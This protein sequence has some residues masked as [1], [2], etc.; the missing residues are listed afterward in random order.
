MRSLVSII[1]PSFN[2]VTTINRTIQSV[3]AQDYPYIE[4]IVIDGASSD[5]TT[6]IL[7]KN[8]HLRWI[9]EPDRGQSDA[10]NKGF[11][12]AKGEVIGW[13]N[14]DDTYN[15]GAV[16]AAVRHLMAEPEV[17]VVYSH[18]NIIDEH[19]RVT[20][21]IVAPPFDLAHDL[22]A[23]M[24]PQP[25]AFFRASA[26]A[27][28]GYVNP[29]LHYVMDRDLFMR[30]GLHYRFKHV[31]ATWANFRECQGTK[32]VSHPERFWLEVVSVFEQFLA[33]SD[34]PTSVFA[35]KAQ[36]L[37]R[38]YWLAGI[39][40]QTQSSP[41]AIEQGH[42][43]CLKALE[44]Y[45]LLEQDLDFAVD[46]LIHWAITQVGYELG[47]DYVRR[48][49]TG[50]SLNPK[51]GTHILR[52]ALGHFYVSMALMGEQ[53]WPAYV[54]AQPQIQLRWLRRGI[55]YDPRWLY[56]RGVLATMVRAYAQRIRGTT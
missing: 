32:T 16:S 6:E 46:Q 10:L 54:A 55:A 37:A 20:G 5:G 22:L 51:E 19:D 8:P 26:L 13:L 1:T 56:N 25:T 29:D 52:L 42:S 18:C 39:S 44:T 47:E 31:D 15:P 14:A 38:A 50:L 28:V 7:K 53:L 34:L 45:P 23:H 4:H 24:L 17:A 40:Q 9:S 3:L 49:L 33:R 2:S 12:M 36:A 41:S 35:V 43:Y 30:L 48:V 27:H 21:R 11:R